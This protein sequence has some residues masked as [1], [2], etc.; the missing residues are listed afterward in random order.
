MGSPLSRL[1]MHWDHE[2]ESR[3]WL[4][5][6]GSTFRFM[7]SPHAI[8]A[9]IGPMNSVAADISPRIISDPKVSAD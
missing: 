9:H 8:V 2:R 5:I 1:R 7:E 4:E 6:N 3:K